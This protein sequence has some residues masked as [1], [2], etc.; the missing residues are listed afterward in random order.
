MEEKTTTNT[1]TDT[2]EKHDDFS[3]FL[4]NAITGYYADEIVDAV[5][6]NALD[7]DQMDAI[8]A[9][10]WEL[11]DAN[12]YDELVGAFRMMYLAHNIEMPEVISIFL[13]TNNTEL[14]E[15][16]FYEFLSDFDDLKFDYADSSEESEEE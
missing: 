1:N 10:L 5:W 6:N 9:Y 3:T 13:Q 16:F 2:L 14:L 7:T 4:V 8:G 11:Y 12:K 15:V